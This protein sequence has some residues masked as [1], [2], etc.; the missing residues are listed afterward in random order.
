MSIK[1]TC[2]NCGPRPVEEFAY[3]E[4]PQVPDEIKA[5]GPEAFE[6]DFGYMRHNTAGVQ[7]EAWFHTYGC[8]RWTYIERDTL[9]D[10]VVG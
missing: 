10:T 6:F 5:E 8:R 4:V 7:T 3:G 9:T 2:K 1:I